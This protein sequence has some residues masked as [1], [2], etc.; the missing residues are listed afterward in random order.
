MI[1]RG[2]LEPRRHADLQEARRR[3]KQMRRPCTPDRIV[4]ELS[5]GFWR[6]LLSARYEQS[7]W[8]P[9]LRH[10]FPY[11][12]PQRRRD[13]ADRVQRLH[14]VRNRLAHHEPVHGRDLAHDQADLLFVTRAICPVASSWI[15]TT[16][17]LRQALRRRPGG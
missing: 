16:S 6:Y 4:S 9:A 5:L 10:A 15:D 11:L 14:L 7:L 1:P 12:R 13:I 17:T 2:E 8:T 3:I